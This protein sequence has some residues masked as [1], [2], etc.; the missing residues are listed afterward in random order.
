MEINPDDETSY[1]TQYQGA[2]LKNVENE[3]YAKHQRLPVRKPKIIPNRNLV[4]SGIPSTSGQPSY[5]PY[6][7]YSNDEEY[8]MPKNVAEMTPGRR[9]HA[10]RL[11]IAAR[12]YLN[13]P[14]ELPRNWGQIDPNLND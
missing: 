1:T 5:N 12:L 14:S 4:S 2:F 3:Y 9:D 10:A 7:L 11:L 6:D 13:S 8:L